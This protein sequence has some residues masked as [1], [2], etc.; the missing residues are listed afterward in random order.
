MKAIQQKLAL[1]TCALLSGTAGA[2]VD[3][4]WVLDT[5]YLR[6]Q[7]GDDRI[8]VNKFVADVQGRVSESN[9]AS[10]RLVHDT[11][12]GASP[13]GAAAPAGEQVTFTSASGNSG[14]NTGDSG[15][16]LADVEDTRLAVD[17]EWRH[18]HQ[19][20]F[21][22]I[23]GAAL[24]NEND[25]ESAGLSINIEKETTSKLTTFSTGL[26]YTN[27]SIYR[28]GDGATP[29]PLG[30]LGNSESF[31]KGER[32]TT[33]FVAGVSRVLNKRT[34]AQ[35][36]LTYGFSQGYHTDPYKVVSAL[37]DDGNVVNTYY[38]S[39]PDERSRTALYSKLAHELAE[40]RALHLSY[41]YYTDD[42]DIGSHTLDLK[43]RQGFG[44]GQ[45][46][47]PHLRYYKQTAAGFYTP[48]LNV[49]ENVAVQLPEDGFAS[50]DYRLDAFWSYTAGIKYGRPL[51]KAGKLRLRAEYMNQTF[52][53]AYYDKNDAVIVQASYL[54]AF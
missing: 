53:S 34:V 42:W 11:I 32:N 33:D 46:I 23:W 6:Y 22:S 30:E 40:N 47:E 24:S 38:E 50:A 25:Y 15:G 43:L 4:D 17:G 28:S 45:Y 13:T 12:S 19:R 1:A 44:R 35:L 36:N 9:E 39:R 16:T 20:G 37:D 51:G 18:E 21:S 8:G 26:A 5:S 27:D 41:R 48:F 14:F 49:D 2:A 52:S 54:Y 29:D 10:I 3:N 7:E 31:G